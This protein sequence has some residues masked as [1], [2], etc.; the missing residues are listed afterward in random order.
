M[1]KKSE[2]EI[3]MEQD[4]CMDA[5]EEAIHEVEA[6]LDELGD[7]G[8]EAL[9]TG[10][11]ALI[12]QIMESICYITDQLGS[13]KSLKVS[14]KLQIITA[15]I[16]QTM[17]GVLNTV[18][19]TSSSVN[20]PNSKKLA[21][22]QRQLAI[23]SANSRQARK[24]IS[25]IMRG[26]SPAARVPLTADQRAQAMMFIQSRHVS[27]TGGLAANAD[28]WNRVDAEKKTTDF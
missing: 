26:S 8:A 10:D 6:Q 12:D 3:R 18:G 19:R 2:V 7:A 15:H 22:L 21:K 11:Q 28:V 24:E 25:G 20:M 27:R 5:L 4:Q 1:S 16:S 17:V 23:N 9:D 13:L 14:T